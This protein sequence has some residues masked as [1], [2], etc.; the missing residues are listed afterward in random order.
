VKNFLKRFKTLFLNES[1]LKCKEE[2][3]EDYHFDFTGAYKTL[4]RFSHNIIRI[5]TILEVTIAR[6]VLPYDQ[7][8]MGID[9]TNKRHLFKI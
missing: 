2:K 8:H 4:K 3:C 7:S 9:Y 6:Q 5:Q 1:V